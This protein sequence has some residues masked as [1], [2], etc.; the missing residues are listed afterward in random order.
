MQEYYFTKNDTEKMQQTDNVFHELIYAGSGSYTLEGML[1]PLHRKATKYRLISLKH[2]GSSKEYLSE[3]SKIC[4]A[5][6]SGD[7]NGAD[8]AMTEHIKLAMLS[9][10]AGD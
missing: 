4:D 10:L 8:T 6:L 7:E 3:H 5:I 2:N 9:I 1:V